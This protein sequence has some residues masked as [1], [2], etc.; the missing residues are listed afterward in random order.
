MSLPGSL[1]IRR[2]SASTSPL[3]SVAFRQST[4][5]SVFE[6]T[7]FGE[8][9]ITSANGVVGGTDGTEDIWV[10]DVDGYPVLVD[11]Q[12]TARTPPPM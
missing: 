7:S 2:I 4:V 1:L 11:T 10:V 9:F 6:T 12:Q 3:T 8:L 5:L